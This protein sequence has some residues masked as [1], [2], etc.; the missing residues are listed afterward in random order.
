MIKSSNS[1]LMVC[2][3]EQGLLEQNVQTPPPSP[4]SIQAFNKG[5]SCSNGQGF[6]YGL[7]NNKGKF[8]PSVFQNIF[9]CIELLH[10]CFCYLF[11][12]IFLQY[13]KAI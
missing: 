10:I 6:D 9:L 8:V 11:S 5:T 2:F 12:I 3:T 13:I 1:E 4:F 7:G